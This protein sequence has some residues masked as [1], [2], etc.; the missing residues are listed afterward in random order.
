[1]GIRGW[2]RQGGVFSAL[3][4]RDY[5]VFW[6]GALISNTGTWVQTTALLWYV[7]ET[8]DSNAWVGAV[9]MS[10]YLPILLLALLAGYVADRYERKTTVVATFSIMLVATLVLA[11]SKSFGVAGL[12][13]IMATTFVTGAAYAVGAPAA[14]SFLPDLVPPEDMLNALALSTAQFNLG[15]V[16]GPMLGAIIVASWSVSAA[17]YVNAASY[18]T[19][20]AAFLVIK[21][22]VHHELPLPGSL[23]RHITE[24]FRYALTRRWMVAVLLALAGASFIGFS[25]TVLYPSVASDV[26]GQQE[27][28]YG[29]LLSLTGIG[30][31]VGAPL[32]TLLNRRFAEKEIIKGSILLQGL[33]LALLSVSHVYW[34]SC[35]AALGIGCSY[36]MLC[37]ASNTVL[38]ARSER[39]MRGRVVSFYIMMYLG[40]FSLGGQLVGWL[41][42]WR[43]TPFALAVG[44][45]SCIV[46][47]LA[48][49]LLPGPMLGADAR[50]G[51][52]T[53]PS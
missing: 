11:V 43:S 22:R 18:A 46:I 39:G 8:Y 10:N 9:N 53:A 15:R 32:V 40:T 35:L 23:L 29:V 34:L 38:Q 1:M 33:F 36:L 24:G 45:L 13:V 17:F 30:A 4:Q 49:F 28:A 20:I 44:G 2:F 41:A 25:C 12:P 26:L 19:I 7:K 14:I 52:D 47:A 3:G 27:E 50:L 37:S 51:L 42:D 6:A 21:P 48:L 16:A 5:S 31:A